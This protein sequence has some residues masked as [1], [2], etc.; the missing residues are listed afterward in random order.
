MDARITGFEGVMA[1]RMSGLEDRL[2]VKLEKQKSALLLWN[3]VFWV[4]TIGAVMAM[5]KL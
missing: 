3:F 2:D 5:L 1:A 4:G